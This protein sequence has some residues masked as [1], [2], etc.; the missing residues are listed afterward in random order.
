M[1]PRTLPIRVA[2]IPGEA[3]ESWLGAIA[4]RLQTPWGDLLAALEPTSADTPG[5]LRQ[6]L[7]AYLNT[8][9]AAA[10]AHAT[11]IWQATVEASTLG[12]HDGH[13]VTVDHSTGRVRSPWKSETLEILPAM[14]SRLERP[15]AIIVATAVDLYLPSSQLRAR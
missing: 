12:H 6:N 10:I 8:H 9:E 13:L 11:G 3:L 2:P 14:S 1:P 5:L 7:T 4:Q 15:L